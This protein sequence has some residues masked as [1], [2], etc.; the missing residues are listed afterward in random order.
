MTDINSV[1]SAKVEAKPASKDAAK[2]DSASTSSEA[3]A[4]KVTSPVLSETSTSLKLKSFG[5]SISPVL[6]L[7]R[8]DAYSIFGR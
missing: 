8:S 1:E 5:I 4:L 6:S 7:M 2:V 3:D